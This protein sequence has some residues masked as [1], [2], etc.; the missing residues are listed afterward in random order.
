MR[1]T[2]GD[3]A[4]RYEAPLHSGVAC[5]RLQGLEAGETQKFWVGLSVYEPGGHAGEAAAPEE[6][7]YTVLDGELTISADGRDEVLR[8]HD[9]VHL[10]KG[11]VR[12]LENRAQSPATLLVTIATR[13]KT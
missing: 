5:R 7:V 12:S 10:K 8:R 1:I 4:P 3:K 11:E 6:T 9:S 13:D 2:R